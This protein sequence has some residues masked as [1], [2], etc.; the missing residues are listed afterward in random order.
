M[1]I[2]FNSIAKMTNIIRN[3]NNILYFS[4]QVKIHRDPNTGFCFKAMVYFLIH[5]DEDKIKTKDFKL[6]LPRVT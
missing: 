3:M 1:I 4:Y 5:I 2:G 6:Y